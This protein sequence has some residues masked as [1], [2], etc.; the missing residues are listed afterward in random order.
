VAEIR[1]RY[2]AHMAT[3]SSG[4]SSDTALDQPRVEQEIELD[5]DAETVGRALTDADELASWLGDEVDLDLRPGG[6]G[7]VVDEDGT[8]RHV[9]VTDVEPGRVAWHWWVDGGELSTVEITAVPIEVG[10]RVRIVETVAAASTAGGWACASVAPGRAG[11]AISGIGA[12]G[13]WLARQPHLLALGR[14]RA[15]VRT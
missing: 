3:S 14:P 13:T 5:A 4:S 9:L 11:Q 2:V 7:R 1:N 6:G 15:L 12:P 10:T 8:V